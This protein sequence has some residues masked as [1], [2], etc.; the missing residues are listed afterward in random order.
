MWQDD[1]SM[2]SVT[3]VDDEAIDVCDVIVAAGLASEDDVVAAQ[4][5]ARAIGSRAETLLLADATV[6]LRDLSRALATAWQ[7]P[8]CD[9]GRTAWDRALA[10]RFDPQQM[11]SEGWFPVRETKGPHGP[12]VTVATATPPT[13]TS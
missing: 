5:R 4:R 13:T 11:V 12:V 3:Q 6:R 1:H 9:L 2:W 7:V 8:F 10:R